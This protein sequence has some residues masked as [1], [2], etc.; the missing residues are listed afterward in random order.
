MRFLAPILLVL[1]VLGFM[2]ERAVACGDDHGPRSS[3]CARGPRSGDVETADAPARPARAAA[4]T[5]SHGHSANECC[6]LC[7]PCKPTVPV[8]TPHLARVVVPEPVRLAWAIAIA[9]W[10]EG[11]G[12]DCLRVASRPPATAPP[13]GPTLAILASTRSRE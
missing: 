8:S 10:S 7:C 4:P 5:P 12:L 9:T 1:A 11:T 6:E 2:P 13:R 3:S